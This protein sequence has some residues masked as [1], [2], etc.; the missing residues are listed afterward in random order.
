MASPVVASLLD[1]QHFHEFREVKRRGG[2]TLKTLTL[3][4][5][6]MQSNFPDPSGRLIQSSI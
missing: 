5:A 6:G 2:N 4:L 3:Y 1:R